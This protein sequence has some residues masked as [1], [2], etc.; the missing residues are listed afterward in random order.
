[1]AEGEKSPDQLVE[2][3][4]NLALLGDVLD[5]QAPLPAPLQGT[6]VESGQL[7]ATAALVKAVRELTEAV[8]SISQHLQGT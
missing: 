7:V 1:M 4:L 8:R 5:P 2:D 3:A 6:E